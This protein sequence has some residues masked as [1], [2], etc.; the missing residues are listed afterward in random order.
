MDKWSNW[1]PIYLVYPIFYQKSRHH[2]RL[3]ISNFLIDP[4]FIGAIALIVALR[5]NWL[6]SENNRDIE[7]K[8]AR[9]IQKTISE[10]LQSYTLYDGKTSKFIWIT[11][12]KSRA[13]ILKDYF[14]IK[15]NTLRI[16]WNVW[17]TCEKKESTMIFQIL[18]RTVIEA[19]KPSINQPRFLFLLLILIIGLI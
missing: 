12:K 15:Q 8:L 3:K 14:S 1:N 9:L 4:N 6:I 7:F 5:K 13:Y 10:N 11:L 16:A 2:P 18:N 19:E 17:I